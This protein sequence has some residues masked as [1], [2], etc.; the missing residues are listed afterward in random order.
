MAVTKDEV[1]DPQ[2]LDMWLTVNGRRMQT[3]NTATMIFTVAQCISHLSQLF[4]LHPGDVISTGTPPGVGGG[5]KPPTFLK[6]GD[7]GNSAS[8]SWASN[9]RMSSRMPEPLLVICGLTDVMRDRL[10]PHYDLHML[11]DI[12]DVPAWLAEH[13]TATRQVLTDGHWGVSPQLMAGLPNLAMISC[14]GVGYDNIDTDTW[15]GGTLR[16]TRRMCSTP[17]WQPARSCC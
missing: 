10:A 1:G 7:V 2:N 15:C 13:G 17:K 3:G 16:P 9:V 12:N 6:A 4:T 11:K 8:K 14:Y 5:M